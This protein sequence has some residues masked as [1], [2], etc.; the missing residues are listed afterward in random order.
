MN[1]KHRIERGDNCPECG[2][3]I[4]RYEVSRLPHVAFKKVMYDACFFENRDLEQA[5]RGNTIIAY[6]EEI[7][8]RDS[9]RTVVSDGGLPETR[10]HSTTDGER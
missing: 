9:S 1:G 4:L 10:S 5:W 8:I 2:K 6:H 3:E 7:E